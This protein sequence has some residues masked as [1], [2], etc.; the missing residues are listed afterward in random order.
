M[1]VMQ[2]IAADA[3]SKAE[4]AL[5]LSGP[6]DRIGRRLWRIGG[7]AAALLVAFAALVPIDSGAMAPGIEQ[8]QDKRKTVQH[9]DGGVIRQIHV[10]EGSVVK[11]GQSLISL[12]DTNARMTVSVYQAQSDALRAERATLEAQLL[13]KAQIDFPPDLLQRSSDPLVASIL[14]SQ[15]AA[16][17][18]RRSDLSGKKAQLSEQISQ[19]NDEISGDAAGASA[20][21]EQIALL[22]NEISDVSE[23]Y[24]KG[25]ATKTRLLALQ[26]AAAELRGERAGLGADSAKLR[27]KQSEVRI[28]SMQADQ[29]SATE[30]ANSLR[31]IQSQLAEIEDKL[32]AAK[33][34]LARTEIRAPVSGVVVGLRPTTI[35]G[36]I[37]P[38][39]P[40]M[41]VV[42]EGGNLVV[43]AKVT[44][45]DV[46]NLHV[47]EK[48]EVR[49]DGSG[50]RDAPVVE[51]TLQKLSADALT[52]SRGGLYFE[53]EVG[54]PEASKRA[55]PPELLRPGVPATVLIKT[56][57]RT[58]LAYLFEPI[59]RARFNAVREH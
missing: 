45:R 30:A 10:R 12:D 14:R 23:L 46:D 38:S 35:G 27:G 44:P 52:D 9:P 13:G 56:G 37:R 29:D 54:V 33:Q 59:L 11:A 8:V 16:F 48:A 50:A 1:T 25:Y 53:A 49:F 57:R 17:N 34:V 42:P 22:D 15:R 6:S 40:L 55:L 19:L 18:A 43:S 5:H 7:S 41:D 31:T 47:G 32:L 51:G 21:A 58:L 4:L 28:L 20:R 36:V 2:P 26:R 39:E 24:K 3:A